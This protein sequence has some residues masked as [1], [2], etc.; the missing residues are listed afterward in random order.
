MGENRTTD[1][2][3]PRA[4][5]RHRVPVRLRHHWKPA[6]AACAALLAL[7]LFLG[8]ARIR[9]YITSEPA[10]ADAV[11]QDIRGEGD[12]FDG[13][14]HAIEVAFDETEYADMMATFRDEGEKEF[15][16]ADIT[17]DGTTV[18][19]VGLRLKGNSTLMSLR[20]ESGPGGGAETG[21]GTGNGTGAEQEDARAAA[22]QGWQGGGP[23]AVTLSEDDPANL[24]WLIS[25]EEFQ[26]GRAYQGH[27]E[28]T[29]R[30]ATSASATALN[31]AL[32]LDLTA[33]DG[34]TTQDYAFTSFAVNGGTAV[35]RLVLDSPDAAWAEGFGS[36]VLYKG[37]ADGSF[38]Y[39]GDDPTDYEEAFNQINAEGSYDLQPVMS[40][41]EFVNESDDEEFA[42]ELDEHL[43]VESFAR[44][45]AMQDLLSNND[46]MDGPGNNYYLW[47]DTG[48]DR[49]TVLSW[50]LNLSFS[51]MG[52]GGGRA[53]TE[54]ATEGTGTSNG[55]AMPEGVT[56]PEGRERPEGAEMPE[57]MAP[58]EGGGGAE[59]AGTP[60][61]PGGAGGRGGSAELTE[62]FM[63]D[64]DF[65][66]LYE[67]AY[68]EMYADLVESGEAEALLDAAATGA[69]AAGDTEAAQARERLSEAVAAVSP[70]PTTDEG[71]QRAPQ[72]E[73]E[74]ANQQEEEQE[75]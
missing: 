8:D 72:D 15:I 60:E 52:G 54:E 19:D 42:A 59:G 55:T 9:P 29:L 62:R 24:P 10:S 61:G 1:T 58:P 66:A 46:A 33:A 57:G 5:L 26:E 56:P 31:E 18:T 21:N 6:A 20:G 73:Q 53:P 14:E 30:P 70:T 3:R 68:T 49:F 27:T 67:Q 50:D 37:R 2:H 12:L 64:E 40:L 17:I 75:E 38:A 45:L 32:A 23:G 74:Q 36:G 35:P 22:G 65:T 71:E 39:L 25:F 51:S 69:E 13:G 7:A 48:E 41:L 4:R 43:D 63:A 16:S 28:I 44:Y 47:Y 34:Q 11:T